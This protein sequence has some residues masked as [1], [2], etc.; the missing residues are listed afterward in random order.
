MNLG[1]G[2]SG[3]RSQTGL[4]ILCPGRRNLKALRGQ[5]DLRE[6]LEVPNKILRA[7]QLPLE[8]LVIFRPTLDEMQ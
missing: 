7:L 5:R 4:P 3:E 2:P 8:P 6:P 1:R